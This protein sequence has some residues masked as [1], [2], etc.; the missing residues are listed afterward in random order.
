[1]AMAAGTMIW[2]S[3]F[4]LSDRVSSFFWQPRMAVI[5]TT[6]VTG[7]HDQITSGNLMTVDHHC[8]AV[9]WLCMSFKTRACIL[10]LGQS[11]GC[12]AL[13]TAA[14]GLL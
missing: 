5:S 4:S 3:C 1:M 13:G 9:A 8:I 7:Q 2:F 11:A 12:L 10:G 6:G 14:A